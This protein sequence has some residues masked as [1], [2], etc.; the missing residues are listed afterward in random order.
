M[1]LRNL[2]MLFWKMKVITDSH[3]VNKAAK[4]IDV[5]PGAF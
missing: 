4:Y 2:I 5:L 1:F 3:L